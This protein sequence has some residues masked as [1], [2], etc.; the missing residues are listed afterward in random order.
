M[1]TVKVKINL[2]HGGVNIWYTSKEAVQERFSDI[3]FSNSR[4]KTLMKNGD[5]PVIWISNESE[6]RIEPILAHEAIHATYDLLEQR[7][8]AMDEELLAY[9]VEYIVSEG[10]KKL[11]L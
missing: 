6:H 8:I 10:L 2:L 4:G 11:N 7:R 5:N 3:D 9:C 1:K